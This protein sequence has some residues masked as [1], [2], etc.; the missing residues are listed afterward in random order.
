MSSSRE[1]KLLSRYGEKGL[2]WNEKDGQYYSSEDYIDSQVMKDHPEWTRSNLQQT[3]GFNERSVLLSFDDLVPDGPDG[4]ILYRGE[5]KPADPYQSATCRNI[6]MNSVA[7]WVQDEYI[8]SGIDDPDAVADRT[9]IET[10]LFPMINN[11]AS[12]SIVNGVTDESW[13]AYKQDLETYGYY[14]WIEWYNVNKMN[15]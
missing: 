2:L 10:D 6:L 9:L 7:E 11:F 13:N 15:K 4:S 12:T 14:D 1:M 3:V 8:P 5:F